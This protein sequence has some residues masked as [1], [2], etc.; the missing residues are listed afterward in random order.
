MILYNEQLINYMMGIPCSRHFGKTT[1]EMAAVATMDKGKDGCRTGPKY[2]EGKTW[3]LL[4]L[5]LA[6]QHPHGSVLCLTP[7][8]RCQSGIR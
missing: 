7:R 3:T 5:R 4:L 6:S 1:D 2:W 8:T